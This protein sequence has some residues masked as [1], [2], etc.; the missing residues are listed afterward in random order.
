MRNFERSLITEWR[1]L[2][3]PR[4]DNVI[5]V[6][7]SGGADSM[8]L[9]LAVNEL[10]KQNKLDLRIVAAHFNHRLRG[11]ASDEDELFVRELVAER[12]IEF[13]VEHSKKK[14]TSNVEEKARIERYKFLQRTAEN[15]DAFAVLTAHTVDDQAETFL[16]N[17]IRGSG[18]RGLSGMRP[19][20]ELGSQ[21]LLVRPLL[22]WARRSETP[23]ATARST[24]SPY[25][26]RPMLGPLGWPLPQPHAS[27][28]AAVTGAGAW[29][30]RPRTSETTSRIRVSLMAF[31]IGFSVSR[32]ENLFAQHI[33]GIHDADDD[34]V[35]WGILE[36]RGEAG[37]TALAK[38]D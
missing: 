8:S 26:P 24:L 20:R 27:L 21:T 1:R 36:I 38:H 31:M 16:L 23:R 11:V 12:K 28:G 2:Q 6:A 37:G 35:H 30:R 3:L 34:G 13:A 5:I 14:Y 10:K 15:L 19:I 29:P 22:S 9:L 25:L 33:Y 18:I 17:L 32:V 7:I 4:S